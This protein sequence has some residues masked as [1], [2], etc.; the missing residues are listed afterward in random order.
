[1]SK[2]IAIRTILLLVIGVLIAGILVYFVYSYTSTPTLG[3]TECM[4]KVT[5]WCTTCMISGWSTSIDLPDDVKEC[6]QLL[7]GS[8]WDNNDNCG[9]GDPGDS[10]N[11]IKMDCKITVGVVG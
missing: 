1:M 6:G 7:A 3:K 10:V 11:A 8:T 2:G 4:S 9:F 5:S